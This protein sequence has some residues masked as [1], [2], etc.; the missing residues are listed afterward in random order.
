VHAWADEVA[1]VRYAEH[2]TRT[3]CTY[4]LGRR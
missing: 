4:P 2:D 1:L 3:L